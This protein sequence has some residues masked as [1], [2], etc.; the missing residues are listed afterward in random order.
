MRS[1]HAAPDLRVEGAR[2]AAHRG[3]G[4]DDVE[5]RPGVEG[6]DGHDGR[7][8]RVHLPAHDAL[9]RGH[10]LGADL[11]GVHAQVR[12]GAVPAA[13]EDLEL[14]AVHGREA[15]PAA[16]ADRPLGPLGPEVAGDGVVHL[17]VVH[18]ARF[19]HRLGPARAFLGRLEDEHGRTGQARLQPVQDGRRTERHGHVGVV[20]AGVHAA[21][22]G[23]GEGQPGLLGD[24]QGVHVRPDHQGRPGPAGP[25]EPDDAGARNPAAHLQADRGEP[26]RHVGRGLHLLKTGLGDLVQLSARFDHQ[27]RPL[28]PFRAH[29]PLST[30]PVL[31]SNPVSRQT[32]LRIYGT[33]AGGNSN[34]KTLI[35]V[36]PYSLDQKVKSIHSPTLP[37]FPAVRLQETVR[38]C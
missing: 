23:G 19:D 13:A 21:G 32:I 31:M 6:P 30:L 8:D 26:R 34:L 7:L 28:L 22:V 35:L 1:F 24:R 15:R 9:Q 17:G 16:D 12:L 20:A 5:G 38:P 3:L 27:R 11:D 10:D 2:G 36:Q 4:G 37:Y 29:H 14:E 25:E 33:R 18:D